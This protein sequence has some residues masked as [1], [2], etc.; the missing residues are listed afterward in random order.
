[1]KKII[2]KSLRRIIQE[3]SRLEEYMLMNKDWPQKANRKKV[4]MAVGNYWTSPFQV[5]S[6]HIA[7]GFV[8]AGWDV[9][10]ISDPI[11]PV[12]LLGGNLEDLKKRFKIYGTGGKNYLE[13]KLWTYIP[14]AMF[15]PHNKPFL[16]SQFVAKNWYKFTVPNL[17]KKIK[18]AGFEEVDL[19]YFDSINQ[20][21][22]LDKINHKNS[23]LRIADK[24]SG[25]RKYTSAARVMETRLAQKV[26]AVIY[27]A[28][29]LEEYVKSLRPKKMFHV[30]NGVNFEHFAGGSRA[31]PPD[32]RNI[33]RPI[34]IYVG[35]MDLWFDYDLVSE[36]ARELPN[37][38]F[39]L[40]GPAE[41]A[42]KKLQLL[43]NIHLLGPRKYDELPPYLYNSDV[44]IIPFDVKGHADL[45]NSIHPLKLYE[46]MAC[47]LPVVSVEWQEIKKLGS[48]A[49]LCN[50]KEDFV[51]NLLELH[52]ISNNKIDYINYAKR[53]N[54]V[55]R[56]DNLIKIL[57]DL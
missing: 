27:S 28:H 39:V 34:A 29:N 37:I 42:R 48:P 19:L 30:P 9:A 2:K 18:N 4:L 36:A 49:I 33:P 43:Q 25:F 17:V 47:G 41:L 7:K 26:D 46:Y 55:K 12:H 53:Q 57:G 20:Y 22:W 38:S 35:A 40:I 3:R 56:I 31:M 6:H 10:F 24:N 5:G 45:V 52:F 16:R 1:M 23:I 50:S 32:Y 15:T 14:F 8:E 51:K 44:G 21:F 11:S 54:W 13:G